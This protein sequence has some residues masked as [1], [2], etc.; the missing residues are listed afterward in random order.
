MLGNLDSRER[1]LVINEETVVMNGKMME[2]NE[3][4][5]DAGDEMLLEW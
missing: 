5:T 2:M 3:R 4:K 1:M